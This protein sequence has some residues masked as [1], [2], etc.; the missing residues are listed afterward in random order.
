MRR[1][2][3]EGGRCNDGLGRVRE[4]ELYFKSRD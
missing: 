4:M 1:L 2:G 3:E